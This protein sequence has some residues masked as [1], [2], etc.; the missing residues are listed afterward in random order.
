[1]ESFLNTL[2]LLIALTA[3]GV[4][5]S[6]LVRQ[7]RRGRRDPLKEWT[8]IVCMLVFLFFAVSLTDDLHSNLALYDECLT[9]LRHSAEWVC[10][11]P[12]SHNPSVSSSPGAAILPRIALFESLEI[13]SRVTAESHSVCARMK[14][15]SF[16]GR[17]PP[18][19]IL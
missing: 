6:C 19:P 1:M 15:N 9:G 17:A 18:I 14:T 3:L 8:S 7:R 12:T 16:P 10:P 2:W 11:H 5:Q 4:W 13:A